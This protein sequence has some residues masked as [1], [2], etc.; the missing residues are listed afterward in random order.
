MRTFTLGEVFD[1]WGVRFTSDCLGGYCASGDRVL[2]VYVN[3][4][5][6]SRDPRLLKLEAHQEIVV[7]SGTPAKLPRPT[8]SSYSFPQGL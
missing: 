5:P 8:P 7:A 1:V 2:R 4:N 3:G 6:V